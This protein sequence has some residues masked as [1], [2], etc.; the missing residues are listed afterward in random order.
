MDK[1][2]IFGAGGTGQRVYG[3]IKNQYEVVGFADN[4]SDRWGE[5]L[6]GVPIF[7]PEN[8][9]GGG[10][11]YDFIVLGTLMGYQELQEQLEKLGVPSFKI[12]KGYVEQSVLSR[13]YFLKRYAEEVYRLGIDGSVGEA[14]VFRGEFAKEINGY[15][16]DRKCYLFDTFEGFA[17][18][19]IKMEKKESLTNARYMKGLSDKLVYEKMPNKNMV[20]IFKGY[21]PETAEGIT[22][23]F[24]FVNLDMDLYNP[25]LGGLRFFYPK[26]SGGGII[27]IHDYFSDAYPNLRQAVEDYETE[28]GKKLPKMPIGDDISIAITKP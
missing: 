23:S 4:G 3:L 6:F 20:K 5:K 28:I 7:N 1:A 26:L 18:E 24:C 27:L 10:I 13:I 17:E 21:F 16:P 8:I 14:G 11:K 12:V 9:V 15:F 19:D 25:T 2:I 22:D